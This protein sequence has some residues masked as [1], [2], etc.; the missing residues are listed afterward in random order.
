MKWERRKPLYLKVWRPKM[1]RFL[2]LLLSMITFSLQGKH[3]LQQ[4]EII[5]HDNDKIN[6]F[7]CTE[8]IG[9]QVNSNGSCECTNGSTILSDTN[10]RLKC[11]NLEDPFPS[12]I[13]NFSL[14]INGVYEVYKYILL[15]HRMYWQTFNRLFYWNIA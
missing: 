5:R 1:H 11:E 6:G 8:I 9:A 10:G 7:N 12:K 15:K 14:F 4:I 13:I 3:H 2:N